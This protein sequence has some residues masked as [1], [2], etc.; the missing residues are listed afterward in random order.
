M[1]VDD[2]LRLAGDAGLAHVQLSW[3]QVAR[4]VPRLNPGGSPVEGSRRR[5]PEVVIRGHFGAGVDDLRDSM[6][7]ARM[8][9]VGLDAATLDC[10][11]E[12]TFE[13]QA[14]ELFDQMQVAESLGAAHI[15]VSA[16]PRDPAN[17]AFVVDILKRLAVMHG[18]RL[19]VRNRCHSSVEQIEDL[20]RLFRAVG[21]DRLTLDLDAAEFQAAV[22][23]P[24][25][26]V[27]SFARRTSRVRVAGA[28]RGAIVES[29]ERD[30]F[31]GPILIPMDFRTE[32]AA[33]Q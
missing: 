14:D 22:V 17:F 24:H 10:M 33:R 3:E 13:R 2:L 1:P 18:V 8:A 19:A 4:R 12:E 32:T 30:G 25:D 20:H 28:D 6:R 16:G 9:V 23:N 31:S 27:L 5:I 26:A 15:S 21:V 29:L 11:D 7:S